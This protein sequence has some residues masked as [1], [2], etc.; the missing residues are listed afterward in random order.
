MGECVLDLAPAGGNAKE[1]TEAKVYPSVTV[2]G[3]YVYLSNDHGQTFVLDAS[4]TL[5]EI[6]RNRLPEG[7]GASLFFDGPDVFIRGGDYLY[8]VG[9]H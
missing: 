1:L 3:K 4:N 7:S 9:V 6:Q 8:C 2:A 5:K